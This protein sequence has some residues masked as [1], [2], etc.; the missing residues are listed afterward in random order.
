MPYNRLERLQRRRKGEPVPLQEA[1][2]TAVPASKKP[3]QSDRGLVEGQADS[4]VADQVAG[5][6]AV[7]KPAPVAHK[8][9]RKRSALEYLIPTVD[10]D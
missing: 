1:D 7:A 9:S 8:C 3:P 10:L 5:G 2:S 6:S 4:N